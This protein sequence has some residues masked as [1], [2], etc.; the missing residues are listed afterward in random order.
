MIEQLAGRVKK[1]ELTGD[2]AALLLSQVNFKLK[3][4]Q[5]KSNYNEEENLLRLI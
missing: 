3:M 2:Q 4:E 1:S 5:V